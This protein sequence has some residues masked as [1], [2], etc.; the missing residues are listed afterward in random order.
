MSLLPAEP[1]VQGISLPPRR[2]RRKLAFGVGTLMLGI[3]ALAAT[4]GFF[5]W[6]IRRAAVEKFMVQVRRTGANARVRW[7][8]AFPGRDYQLMDATGA[9]IP[10]IRQV[11]EAHA[12]DMAVTALV[13][14]LEDDI[15]TKQNEAILAPL[16]ALHF[17]G[18]GRSDAARVAYDI[19]RSPLYADTRLQAVTLLGHLAVTDWEAVRDLGKLL[20]CDDPDFVRWIFVAV[21]HELMSLGPMAG[22]QTPALVA[23]LRAH[24]GDKRPESPRSLIIQAIG[25]IGRGSYEGLPDLI[26][27]LDD[28]SETPL[29]RERAFDAICRLAVFVGPKSELPHEIPPEVS[30][31]IAKYAASEGFLKVGANMTLEAIRQRELGNHRLPAGWRPSRELP[32][33]AARKSSTVVTNTRK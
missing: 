10:A 4:F 32:G 15:K 9:L 26:A 24:A 1:P 16:A 31:R 14:E 19:A 12:T 6:Q 5:G 27:I 28:A 30:K 18:L 2:G 3:A 25:L 17:L 33:A 29:I 11:G 21:V 13:A 20:S 23:S 22:D 7:S 8:G